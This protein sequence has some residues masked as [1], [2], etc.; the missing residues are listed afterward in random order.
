MPHKYMS[1]CGAYIMVH[2][3]LKI[4]NSGLAARLIDVVYGSTFLRK[5]LVRW[6]C[7]TVARGATCALAFYLG[8]RLTPLFP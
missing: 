1:A 3:F 7:T 4:G 5:G 2:A 6:A 8:F